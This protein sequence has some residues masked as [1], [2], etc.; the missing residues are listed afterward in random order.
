MSEP[1]YE[2]IYC[3]VCGLRMMCAINCQKHRAL[4]HMDH[5]IECEYFEHK[6]WQCLY[7][8]KKKRSAEAGRDCWGCN[9]RP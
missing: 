6:F 8:T 3:P 5:C 4:V 7:L 9:P 2:N 1:I